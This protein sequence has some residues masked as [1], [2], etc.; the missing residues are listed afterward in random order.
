MT[1]M[2]ANEQYWHPE[3]HSESSA[4]YIFK[5]RL[6]LY[7]V[8]RRR[9]IESCNTGCND[10]K[11]CISGVRKLVIETLVQIW[12]ISVDNSASDKT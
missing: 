10:L 2:N 12:L 6:R 3:Y 1:H 4:D 9:L 11:L 7:T 8:E 5:W